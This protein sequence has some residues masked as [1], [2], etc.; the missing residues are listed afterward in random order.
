[1]IGPHRWVVFSNRTADA[2]VLASPLTTYTGKAHQDSS[3]VLTASD[4]QE[5]DRATYIRYDRA[6]LFDCRFVDSQRQC[7]AMPEGAIDKVM[8]G[9]Q[10]TDL[11]ELRYA[12]LLSRQG[13]LG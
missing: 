4:Y 3:C 6:N 1:M 8:L 2:K 10:M 7:L 13:L 9:A 11:I 12:E 5:L